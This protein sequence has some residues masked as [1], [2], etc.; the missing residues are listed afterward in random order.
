MNLINCDKCK[1]FKNC[2]VITRKG[3]AINICKRCKK[4]IKSSSTS[5]FDIF[6]KGFKK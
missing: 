5:I 1:K 2:S 3:K 6:I 4:L